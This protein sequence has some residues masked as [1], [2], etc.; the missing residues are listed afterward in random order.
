M[1][2]LEFILALM[3]LWHRYFA[4]YIAS[5]TGS[6][7]NGLNNVHSRNPQDNAGTKCGRR[8]HYQH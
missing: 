6:Q 4:I 5:A 7:R 3:N 8:T 1:D 2:Y